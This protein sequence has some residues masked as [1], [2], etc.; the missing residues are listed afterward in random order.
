MGYDDIIQKAKEEKADICL[1]GHTHN[2]YTNY[3][4]SIHFMNPGAVFM[5]SYGIIDITDKGIIA[6][7]AKI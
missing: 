1:F 5:G 4:D 6:Y 7:N 3:I 2:P